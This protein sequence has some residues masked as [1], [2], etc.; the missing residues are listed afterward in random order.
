MTKTAQKV[1][2]AILVI[3]TAG[4]CYGAIQHAN[5]APP[6]SDIAYDAPTP[7]GAAPTNITSLSVLSDS[8]IFNSG[9]WFRLTVEKGMLKGVGVSTFASTPGGN[10]A[11]VGAK[12]DDVLDADWVIVQAGTNDLIVN[13]S[14]AETAQAVEQIVS[15]VRTEGPKV[16][17]AAIPPSNEVPGGVVQ[18]NELL[19]SWAKSKGVPF[20]DVYSPVAARG[21]TFRDGMTSDDRHANA[22][23][24]R[25]TAEAVTP[26]LAKILGTTVVANP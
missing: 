23:G 13:T 12:I 22:K 18:T 24:A 16:I 20:L 3:L 6:M 21:G 15:D 26:K 19:K 4:L 10:A 5:A 1:A 11:R 2:L 14:P 7:T 17:L 8:H 25:A 9:S